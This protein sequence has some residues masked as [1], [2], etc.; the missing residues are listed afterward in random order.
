MTPEPA[1][2]DLVVLVADG[3]MKSAVEGLLTRGRSLKC[4]DVSSDIYVHPAKDPGCLL[5]AHDFLRP[6]CRQYHRAVVMLDREGSG[7]EGLPREELEAE[8]EQR[9]STSGWGERAAAIV[10]D[11]ELEIWVWSDSPEVDAALGWSGRTPSLAAW[12][13]SQGYRVP[14]QHKP[15]EPKKAM[16][17]ALRIARKQRSSAIYLRLAQRVSIQRC[18][19][20]AFTKFKTVLQRWFGVPEA[21]R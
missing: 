16:E 19:D 21:I 13:V 7:R 9:L 6:F 3:Q 15:Q 12:L 1:V 10:L 8:I 11:P 5:R 4:R 14:G 20:P 18:A 2:K 17:E